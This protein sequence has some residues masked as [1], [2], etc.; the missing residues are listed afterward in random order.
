MPLQLIDLFTPAYEAWTTRPA[1]EEEMMDASKRVAGRPLLEMN[2]K[3]LCT[4]GSPLDAARHIARVGTDNALV[5]HIDNALNQC[6]PAWR[7]AMPRATPPGLTR[8]KNNYGKHDP[9][10]V[11]AEINTH[12]AYLSPG[13]ILFRGGTWTGGGVTGEPLSTSLCP[14]VALRNAEHKGK[15]Y[16]ASYIDLLVLRVISSATKVFAFK[17]QGTTLGHENEVLLAAG[18]TLTLARSQQVRTDYVVAGVS[19]ANTPI[20]TKQVPINVLE[21]DIS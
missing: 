15:A 1:T 8:Y 19:M 11:N 10:L 2:D 13:Q 7:K 17:R 4:V 12:G 6:H 20:P 14:S 16:D 9:A 21:I 18:A 3:L 5:K